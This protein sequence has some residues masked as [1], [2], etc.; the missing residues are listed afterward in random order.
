M[1]QEVSC[2]YCGKCKNFCEA[3]IVPESLGKF[4]NMPK[5][6]SLV[7]ADCDYEIG[8]AEEQLAKCS[9][10]AIFRVHLDIQG[11]KKHKKSSPFRRKHAGQGPIELK[12]KIPGRNYEVLVEPLGDGKNVQPLPQLVLLN[13]KVTMTILF[14]KIQ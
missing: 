4:K 3:H 12:T 1:S 2:I 14:F 10:E 6:K 11:K 9:S 5:Q 7:C 13:S 8:K